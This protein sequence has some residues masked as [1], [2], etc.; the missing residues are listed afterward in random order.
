MKWACNQLTEDADFG[1][2][3]QLILT[4]AGMYTSKTVAFGAQHTLKSLR[5]LNESLFGDFGVP[6]IF[7]HKN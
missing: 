2:T 1:K 3:N 5:N 6:Q 7:V 4:L